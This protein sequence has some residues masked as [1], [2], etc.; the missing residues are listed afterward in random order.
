MAMKRGFIFAAVGI[1]VAV[2]VALVAWA[3]MADDGDDRQYDGYIG[4]YVTYRTS[5]SI[6]YSGTFTIEITDVNKSTGEFQYTTSWSFLS[7]MAG[8]NESGSSERWTPSS[9]DL[10]GNLFTAADMI[11]F[12]RAERISTKDGFKQTNVYSVTLPERT[13]TI[14]IGVDNNLLYRIEIPMEGIGKVTWNLDR[15]NIG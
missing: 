1:A 9:E 14:W 15:T 12:L 6:V 10:M 13:V 8:I 11:E 7:V 2:S 5:S 4:N 3:V